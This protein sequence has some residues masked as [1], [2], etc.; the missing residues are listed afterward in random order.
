[1]LVLEVTESVNFF[2]QEIGINFLEKAF[3]FNNQILLV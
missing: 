2:Y 1:M 3:V